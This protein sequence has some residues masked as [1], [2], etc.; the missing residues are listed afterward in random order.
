MSLRIF[1][2]IFPSITQI[3]EASKALIDPDLGALYNKATS[4]KQSPQF[5]ILIGFSLIST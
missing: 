3:F 1:L 5:N 2:K 4:P